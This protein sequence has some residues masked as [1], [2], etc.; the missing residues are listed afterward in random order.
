MDSL[1]K[2]LFQIQSQIPEYRNH[3]V[4]VRLRRLPDGSQGLEFGIIDYTSLRI[5]IL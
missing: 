5:L 3:L 4:F 2:A 1:L